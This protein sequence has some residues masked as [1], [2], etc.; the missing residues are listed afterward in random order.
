VF[1]QHGLRLPREVKDQFGVGIPIEKQ[2][3]ARGDLLFFTTTSA[4]P[5][6]VAIAMGDGSFVHAPSST[7]VVR[8]ERLDLRYWTERF[9]GARRVL[10]PLTALN[11]SPYGAR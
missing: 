7:G 8:V 10:L 2:Q 6:H 4:G 11:R 9:V 1:A 3:V 5:T